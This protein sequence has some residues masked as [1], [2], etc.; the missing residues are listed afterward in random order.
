M[1]FR[2]RNGRAIR[3]ADVVRADQSGDPARPRTTAW[4][5]RNLS[6]RTLIMATSFPNARPVEIGNRHLQGLLRVPEKAVGLVIFAHGSG[7][8]RLSPRNN[9]VAEG[10]PREGLA[11]LDRKSKRLNSRH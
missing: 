1:L 5:A 8:G 3:C 7:S 9:Y 4:R 10:L 11:T 2:S 6:V